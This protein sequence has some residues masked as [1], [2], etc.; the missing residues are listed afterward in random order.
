MTSGEHEGRI[1]LSYYHTKYGLF[2][3]LKITYSIFILKMLQEVP[4]Y[5]EMRH[6]VGVRFY[7]PINSYGHVEMVSS[8]NHTFFLGKLDRTV[9][10]YSNEIVIN[11]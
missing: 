2:F 6:V 4:K 1:F 10:Q 5:S 7:V 9:N 8:P 3:L 11:L